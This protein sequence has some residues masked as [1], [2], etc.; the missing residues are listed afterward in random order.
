MIG[1]LSQYGKLGIT[2][3][4]NSPEE[5]QQLFENTVKV[6]DANTSGSAAGYAAPM[7]DR[8]IAIE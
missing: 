3:I 1:A 5:A 8:Y 4:G 6:L 7:S 2:S